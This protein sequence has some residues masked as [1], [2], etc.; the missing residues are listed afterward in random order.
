MNINLEYFLKAITAYGSDIHTYEGFYTE[1]NKD[2]FMQWLKEEPKVSDTILFRGYTFDKSYY[3]DAA[4]HVGRIIGL[5]QLT[6]GSLPP[7]F[8]PDLI[9]AACYVR[10]F[11][12]TDVSE[13]VSVLF[14]VKAQGKHFVNISQW[15]YYPEEHEHRCTYDVRLKVIDLS[16]NGSYLLVNLEEV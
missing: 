2:R 1:A 14:K 8:T 3:E 9:R 12:E 13:T 10:E 4:F 7:A 11:G 16:L 5:D 6:Q 15:S